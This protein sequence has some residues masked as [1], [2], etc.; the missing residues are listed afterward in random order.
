MLCALQVKTWMTGTCNDI[1]YK[2]L[3]FSEITEPNQMRFSEM[4]II[5]YNFII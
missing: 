2:S 3:Q 4:Q 1:P 5:G